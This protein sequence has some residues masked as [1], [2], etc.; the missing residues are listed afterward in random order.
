MS[1]VRSPGSACQHNRIADHDSLDRKRSNRSHDCTTFLRL[2]HLN[3]TKILNPSKLMSTLELHTGSQWN[4]YSLIELNEHSILI[5]R[6]L[7][8][9]SAGNDFPV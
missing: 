6:N 4:R 1:L 5:N 2:N 8:H 7:L 9:G 3:L